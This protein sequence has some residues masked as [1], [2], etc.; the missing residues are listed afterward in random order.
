MTE[1]TI[2]TDDLM[3]FADA[4]TALGVSRPTIYNFVR[5]YTL[6]PVSISTNRY[7]LKTEI[8]ELKEKLLKEETSNA[9]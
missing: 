3:T 7:L 6:H 9:D 1:L 5:R 2:R 4:A 8:D